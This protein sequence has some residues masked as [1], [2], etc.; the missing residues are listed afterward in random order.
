M[1]DHKKKGALEPLELE[2][3]MVINDRAG[4]GNQT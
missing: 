2:V 3:Q 4:A 1:S